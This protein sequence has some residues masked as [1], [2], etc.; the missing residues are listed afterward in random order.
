MFNPSS[1][2]TI[3]EMTV[4]EPWPMS[5]APVSTITDPSSFILTMTSPI[6]PMTGAAIFKALK[7]VPALRSHIGIALQAPATAGRIAP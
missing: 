6:I 2:A 4:S 1:S 5:I 3:W 7:A